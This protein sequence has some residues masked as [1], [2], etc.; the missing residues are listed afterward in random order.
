MPIGNLGSK[1]AAEDL[2]KIRAKRQ[3][4]EY[5]EGFGPEDGAGVGDGGDG[6]DELSG[7]LAGGGDLDGGMDTGMG[8]TLPGL[9]GPP[10]GA[11]GGQFGSPPGMGFPGM[12]APGMGAPGMPGGFQQPGMGMPGQPMMPGQSMLGQSIMGN[13][14]DPSQQQQQQQKQPDA[15]DKMFD[16]AGAGGL[17]V[18]RVSGTAIKSVATRNY[19]DWGT[20][21]KNLIVASI[22]T[23]G[24]GFVCILLSIA[25]GAPIFDFTRLPVYFFLTAGLDAVLAA[26]GIVTCAALIAINA[27]KYNLESGL[28]S[29][30][31]PEGDMDNESVEN[32]LECAFGA[33][34]ED[35]D[36]LDSLLGADDSGW[37][38]E[39][40]RENFFDNFG[41]DPEPEPE[42]EPA[43][44]DTSFA[45][46]DKISSMGRV[47]MLTR[48]F[49]FNTFKPLLP[50]NTADFDKRT[51]I[52]EDSEDFVAL[53]ALCLKALAA[54][55]GESDF[56]NVPSRLE[57]AVET[58]YTYEFR[59]KRVPKLKKL[60]DISREIAAYM[61]SSVSDS[62][63]S[64]VTDIEGD[65]YVSTVTKGV[66]AV[67]TFGDVFKRK[68]VCDFYLNTKNL[69]PICV[70]IKMTGE[71]VLADAK[72]FDTMLIAGRPRS[73]K[74]WYVLSFIF[75]LTAFNP[76]EDV[77][78]LIIDPKKSNLMNTLHL[79]PHVCGVVDDSNILDVLDGVIEGE[80]ERR[81]KLL[82]DNHCDKLFDLWELGIKV[83]VLYI[84]IDEYMSVMAHLN[85]GADSEFKEKIKVIISQ[86]PSLGIRLI[87]VPHRSKGVVDVTARTNISF[88]A[89]VRAETQVIKETLDIQKWDTPLLNQ[90][91]TAVKMQGMGDP[92]M[93]S[94]LALTTSDMENAKFIENMARMYYQ[95]GVDIPDMRSI[96]P[97][98]TRNDDEILQE[99]RAK[100]E[101]RHVQQ[102]MDSM[103]SSMLED[104]DDSENW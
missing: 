62:D 54:A 92:I 85:N 17:A 31:P 61:K 50:Q 42:P 95:M 19:D 29:D 41:N 89:A 33:M 58:M 24:L 72:L 37:G 57:S 53:E 88:S 3:H 103:L 67:I 83:P 59:L 35:D 102:D 104:T 13:P 32:A 80:G 73:G 18:V 2:D 74:S 94:G 75:S 100:T 15:M 66:S 8:D 56:T 4:S 7:L 46:N 87:I 23:A 64:C 98:Y 101:T 1:V 68:D 78:I 5:A 14:Y 79:L 45:F 20:Y 34:G 27:D 38:E 11:P 70:G 30:L 76:P 82:A 6:W 12:G 77:Q 49:L 90:G 51:V 43:P 21:C 16:L 52:E 55:M 26:G 93:V 10:G 36:D 97:G 86:L 71:P 44:Q 84:V 96:G 63:I 25:T 40:E 91:D 99:L 28:L 47:P 9:G 69:L 81:K 48:E 39:T 65:F 60:E 22:V